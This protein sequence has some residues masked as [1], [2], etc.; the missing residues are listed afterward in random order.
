MMKIYDILGKE[1]KT[2]VN[3]QKTTGRY[4]V[5]FDATDLAAEFIY[6][7]YRLMIKFSLMKIML[8]N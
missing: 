7:E 2:L 8:L 3:E 4:E 1:A 5:R 6:T